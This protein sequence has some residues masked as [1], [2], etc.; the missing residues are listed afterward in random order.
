MS[1]RGVCT[2]SRD[3]LAGTSTTVILPFPVG[4]AVGDRVVCGTGINQSAATVTASAGANTW[5]AT[6]GPDAMST[7]AVAY[8][9][10]RVLDAVDI[11]AGGVTFTWSANARVQAGGTVWTA[12]DVVTPFGTQQPGSSTASTVTQGTITTGVAGSDVAVVVVSR[13]SAGNFTGVTALP[14]GW[15]EDSDYITTVATNANTE[16]AVGHLTTPVGAG[17]SV[18]GGSITSGSQAT[19]F[20]TYTVELRAASGTAYTAAATTAATA[21]LDAAASRSTSV[22]AATATTATVTAAG[23]VA[24]LAD[25]ALSTTAA[26]TAAAS[27][28]TLAAA[29][30]PLVADLTAAAARATSGDVEAPL[31]AALTA[32]AAVTPAV[33]AGTMSPRSPTGTTMRGA[34]ASR[35]TMRPAA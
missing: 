28:T 35:A 15:T 21:A 27:R 29:D 22:D 18:G 9:F 12:G 16:V 17:A 31:V 25:A 8:F 26:T 6:S 2:S 11:A 20:Y 32:S 19:H 7:A 10:V 33:V 14:A 13:V 5:T 30:S 1:L 3:G 34:T 4:T 24:R 23:T